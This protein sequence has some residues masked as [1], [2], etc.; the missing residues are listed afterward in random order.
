V[1]HVCYKCGRRMLQ[2]FYEGVT[3]VLH[4]HQRISLPS[5]DTRIAAICSVTKALV[6]PTLSASPTLENGVREREAGRAH[7]ITSTIIIVVGCVKVQKESHQRDVHT[8]SHSITQHSPY[9]S[10]PY[11]AAQPVET[12]A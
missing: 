3:K 12:P 2:G 7:R 4:T 9:R 8:A 10:A 1:L 5:G 6:A 11:N